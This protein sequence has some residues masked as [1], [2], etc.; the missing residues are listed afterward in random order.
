LVLHS[1]Q[2]FHRIIQEKCKINSQQ[3]DF[4]FSGYVFHVDKLRYTIF[5]NRICQEKYVGHV[6]IYLHMKGSYYSEK[7]RYVFD[8]CSKMTFYKISKLILDFKK[9]HKVFMCVFLFF[10]K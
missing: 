5:K 2:N 1:L 8:I 4:A 6:G 7:N 9:L 3:M 10:G